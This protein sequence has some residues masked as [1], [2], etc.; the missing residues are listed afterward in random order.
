MKNT[1][2]LLRGGEYTIRWCLADWPIGHQFLQWKRGTV[3][4]ASTMLWM[5]YLR[6]YG[7]PTL[8]EFYRSVLHYTN[9]KCWKVMVLYFIMVWMSVSY[10][11]FFSFCQNDLQFQRSFQV[12]LSVTW[13]VRSIIVPV[14]SFFL[15][16]LWISAL[17]MEIVPMHW[18]KV[19]V[20]GVFLVCIFPYSNWMQK[21][22]PYLS[23]LVRMWEN[24]TKK[25]LNMDI[26]HAVMYSS[27]QK[28][29]YC[30][31]WK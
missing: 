27:L 12:L 30:F 11:S 15:T 2:H 7:S 26:F 1:R 19:S 17:F 4:V 10:C 13:N 18:W 21:D 5:C 28:N 14:I 31:L 22:T 24:R 8:C 25:T 6:R 16:R 3:I 20:L 23:Y 29:S 9:L